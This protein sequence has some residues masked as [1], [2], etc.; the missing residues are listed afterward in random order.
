MSAAE[1]S[2]VPSGDIALLAADGSLVAIAEHEAGS[3]RSIPRRVLAV[4]RKR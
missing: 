1:S 2:T 3:P 4:A